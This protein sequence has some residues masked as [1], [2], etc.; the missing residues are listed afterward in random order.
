MSNNEHNAGESQVAELEQLD[1]IESNELKV[2]NAFHAFRF[3][4]VE[5]L[6][7][8]D[9]NTLEMMKRAARILVKERG[10]D[11]AAAMKIIQ[12]QASELNPLEKISRGII[13]NAKILG[14]AHHD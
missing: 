13:S 12:E 11:E 6:S 8:L 3:K 1:V 5:D 10:I 2:G 14:K 4:N 7:E 9:P